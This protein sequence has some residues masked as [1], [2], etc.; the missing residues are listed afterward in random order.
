MIFKDIN[1]EGTG[2]RLLDLYDSYMK[3]K[4][5]KGKSQQ[6]IRN[7]M[8]L[9]KDTFL[10]FEMGC[11]AY[12]EAFNKKFNLTP[13]LP[14]VVYDDNCEIMPFFFGDPENKVKDVD[15]KIFIISTTLREAEAAPFFDESIEA[16]TNYEKI[17]SSNVTTLF[18]QEKISFIYLPLFEF[19]APQQLGSNQIKLVR[20]DLKAKFKNS[21]TKLQESSTALLEIPYDKSNLPLINEKFSCDFT[22]ET[23]DLQQKID[24]NIYIN[25]LKSRSGDDVRYKVYLGISSFDNLVNLYR[26]LDAID[27]TVALYIK[28]ELLKSVDLKNSC[29]FLYLKLDG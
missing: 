28:E 2:E 17:N 6:A 1:E 16:K 18:N 25:M 7:L 27:T 19:P 13:L 20:N 5:Q 8:K 11:R 15:E 14:F 26:E 4:K 12:V 9:E 10:N 23:K 22:A 24:E 29:I 21:L 3:I